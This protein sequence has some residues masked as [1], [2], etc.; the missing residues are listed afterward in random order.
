MVQFGVTDYADVNP[1]P[2]MWARGGWKKTDYLGQ[3]TE[4]LRNFLRGR[5]RD[6]VTNPTDR[7]GSHVAVAL[8]LIGPFELIVCMASTYMF[9]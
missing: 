3:A 5:I 7:G 9:V 8:T 2:H 4:L 6:R 1:T